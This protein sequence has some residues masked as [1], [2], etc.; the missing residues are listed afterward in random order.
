M[1]STRGIS[2]PYVAPTSTSDGLASKVSLPLRDYCEAT[3]TGT[4]YMPCHVQLDAKGLKIDFLSQEF[5]VPLD[6]INEFSSQCGGNSSCDRDSSHLEVRHSEG[7]VPDPVCI[8]SL[9]RAEWFD[10]MEAFGISTHDACHV[11]HASQ[12]RG[13]VRFLLE[14]GEPLFWMGWVLL[15]VV[16]GPLMALVGYLLE[17]AK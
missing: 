9:N 8:K 12:L 2:N 6:K 4:T 14:H 16:G 13:R 5:Y 17:V 3:V 7:L 11:R 1:T 10:V 15:I